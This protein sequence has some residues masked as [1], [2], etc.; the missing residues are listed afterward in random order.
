[1]KMDVLSW[2]YQQLDDK[3][4]KLASSLFARGLRPG[5]RIA[6]FLPNGAEWALL[7]WASVKLGSIFVSLDERAVPRKDEVHHFFDV[8]KPCAIFVS[9]AANARG[10]MDHTCL[11]LGEMATKVFTE[12]ASTAVLGEE[13]LAD[14]LILG[15]ASN[16]IA[17]THE[18]NPEG[19]AFDYE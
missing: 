15:T 6:L 5:M 16:G 18:E 1:M 9:T 3:A 12:P 14:C 4:E 11:D 19:H 13:S 17:P 10:L 2:T 8:T 7:F